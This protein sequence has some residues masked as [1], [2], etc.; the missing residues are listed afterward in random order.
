MDVYLIPLGSIVNGRYDLYCE[1]AAREPSTQASPEGGSGPFATI[2]R[3]VKAA[4][5][6]IESQ[7]P[8]ALAEGVHGS[9]GWI[10]R[11][12]RWMIRWIAERLAEW[13]LFWRLRKESDLT[14]FFPD[15]VSAER[16]DDI[17]RAILRREASRHL[18]WA[19]VDGL[20]LAVSGIVAI[21]PG[22]NVIAYFFGFRFVGHVLSRRGATH[23]L[24]RVRWRSEPSSQL[25]I[26]RQ[27]ISLT[28]ADRER[29]VHQVAAALRLQH[30]ARFFERTVIPAA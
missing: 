2:V 22:P 11:L 14:L 5:A 18:K 20:L 25:S 12:E 13:R 26:L 27:A 28:A 23:G 15:D 9:R 8:D 6:R 1:P 29:R 24:N 10:G 19:I 16:A 4:V 21:I 3:R 30:L 17:A 7:G